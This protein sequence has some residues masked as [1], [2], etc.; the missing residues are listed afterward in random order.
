M[1]DGRSAM[2]ATPSTVMTVHECISLAIARDSSVDSPERDGVEFE[3]DALANR[4]PVQLPPKLRGT[5]S[6]V[7]H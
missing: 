3:L 4:Q 1:Q 5:Q 6:G 2:S 7:R